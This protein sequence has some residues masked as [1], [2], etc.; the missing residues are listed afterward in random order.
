MRDTST[1]RTL[2]I[3]AA[4][5]AVLLVIWLFSDV[6]LMIFLAVL[7]AA[8]LRSMSDWIARRTRLPGRVALAGVSLL[9]VATLAVL[10]YLIGP[11]LI[12]QGAVLWKSVSQEIH[13]LR[14]AHHTAPWAEWLFRRLSSTT[15]METRLATSAKSIVAFT[16]SGLTGLLVTLVTALYFAIAPDLYLR[17]I[18]LLFPVPYRARARAIL[19]AAGHTLV[20]WSVGQFVD[21]L[22]V[23]SLTAI[24]LSVLGIPL[25]LALA[26][27]AGT[28]T[29]VP[30]FGAILA[31]IPA[32]LL[33]LSIG[34]ET[35]LWVLVVFLCCHVVEAYVVG[36]F[37]QRRTV[38]LPPAL[39]VL[40]MTVLGRLF[41][42]LGLILGAPL[43]A[44]AILV[45]REAYVADVLGDPAGAAGAAAG[46]TSR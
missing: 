10:V 44:V 9:L 17:G 46:P 12:D 14:S 27:L 43:A 13:R 41:G 30:F 25:A 11:K 26:V 1:A 34:W 33:G 15:G 39:T 42:P 23:G 38:R 35:A 28:L 5:A 2:R 29:F 20:L 6:L 36:P 19:L 21:M 24:G 32:L 3:I 8:I 16:A 45:I 31:S 7:L 37:V 22:I 40:S 4:G 18:V